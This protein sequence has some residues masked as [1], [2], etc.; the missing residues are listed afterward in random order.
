MHACIGEGNCNP[1][2]YSCLE[3][4]RD[5][6]AWWAAVIGVAR[7]WTRLKRLTSSSSSL[8]HLSQL[9]RWLSGKE[10]ACNAGDSGSIPGSEWA[11]GEG[12]QP[13]PVFLP[14]GCRSLVGHSSRGRKELDTTEHVAV[15]Q[16]VWP[17]REMLSSFFP[18]SAILG[19][20][21]DCFPV[22]P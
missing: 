12:A 13:T 5:G 14:P 16:Q 20:T 11:P 4:P 19:D 15:F 17:R 6:G 3:N 18:S 2:Q 8:C 9:T 7:G 21:S 1:L 22:C 10:S